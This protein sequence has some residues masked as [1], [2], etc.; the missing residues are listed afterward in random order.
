MSPEITL[1]RAAYGPSTRFFPHHGSLRDRWGP[2]RCGFLQSLGSS[3]GGGR[4]G[5]FQGFEVQAS[6]GLRGPQGTGV[7]AGHGAARQHPPQARWV[8]TVPV[9]SIGRSNSIVAGW[10]VT[11]HDLAPG[12]CPQGWPPTVAKSPDV[13]LSSGV[14]ICEVG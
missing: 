2:G 13:S 7:K 9:C 6:L 14:P 1:R 8:P 4:L 12:L 10:R 3:G 5:G 11:Q